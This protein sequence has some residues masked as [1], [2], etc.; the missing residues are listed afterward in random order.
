MK[1]P[2]P[3]EARFLSFEGI[4]GSGKS[5]QIAHASS[6]VESL[7]F[8]V[9]RVR[10]P[11][12]TALSERIRSLLLDPEGPEIS[13]WAELCLYMAARAQLVRERIAPALERGA[14]VFADRF[15]EASVAYQGGGRGLG[16]D[17]VRSIY[18]HVTEGIH[19]ERVYLLDLDPRAG[20]ARAAQRADRLDRLESE[21]ID[22]HER[23]R[24]AYL[25]QARREPERFVVLDAAVDQE[26]IACR[27]EADL[28]SILRAHLP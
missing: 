10:E 23:V 17:A 26:T 18:D 1:R 3:G 16:L 12:G 15:G 5:T 19:P 21:P 11:G 20:I 2:R 28:S 24:A 4:E 8:E 7:G 27:V 14:I 25:E 9:V 13:P 6:W 22:F